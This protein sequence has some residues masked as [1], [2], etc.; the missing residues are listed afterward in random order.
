MLEPGKE[1]E[2]NELIKLSIVISLQI[3][4]NVVEKIHIVELLNKIDCLT[5][6][7]SFLFQLK[8]QNSELC[9]ANY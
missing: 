3:V 2:E 7:N 5:H 4:R 9:E 6:C 8:N 1:L